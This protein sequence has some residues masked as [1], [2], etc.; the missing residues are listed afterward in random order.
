MS[1]GKRKIVT[2]RRKGLRGLTDFMV[3]YRDLDNTEG[4]VGSVGEEEEIIE[5]PEEG[6]EE[7]GGGMTIPPPI[8]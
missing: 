5:Q 6:G 1:E 7:E 2:Q 3:E 4:E 8:G